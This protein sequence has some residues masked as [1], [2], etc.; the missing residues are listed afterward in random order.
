[1]IIVEFKGRNESEAVS[2]R[3]GFIS[4]MK[5]VIVLEA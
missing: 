4:T 2:C 1:M 3:V 5:K